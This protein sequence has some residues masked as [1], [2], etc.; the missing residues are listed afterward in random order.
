M[1]LSGRG[2]GATLGRKRS[3][4]PPRSAASGVMQRPV[5]LGLKQLRARQSSRLL[6][7]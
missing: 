5:R 4:R 2:A 6:A 7:L 1:P 3:I